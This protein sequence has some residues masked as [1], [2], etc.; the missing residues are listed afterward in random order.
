MQQS[1]ADLAVIHVADNV[2]LQHESPPAEAD[3]FMMRFIGIGSIDRAR[4][5]ARQ[6]LLP[7]LLA[8]RPIA[9]DFRGIEVCTR[10]W[11]QTL[12][13]DAVCMAK[14][15]DYRIWICNASPSVQTSLDLLE[16]HADGANVES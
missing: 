14:G 12:L 4:N 5:F 13:T 10:V 7:R 9:L 6:Q 15:G 8:S 1:N 11:L 16:I 2:I 3:V